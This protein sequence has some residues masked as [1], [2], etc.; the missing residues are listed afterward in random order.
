MAL[1]NSRSAILISDHSLIKNC[2][3]KGIIFENG[4][5]EVN[6]DSRYSLHG[7]KYI[8]LHDT[9]VRV[10]PARVPK[11]LQ[12]ENS[13]MVHTIDVTIV[14]YVQRQPKP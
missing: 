5:F 7:I 8:Y 4:A 1:M 12:S 2:L 9:N 6:R 14:E 11:S 3:I 10:D 13:L